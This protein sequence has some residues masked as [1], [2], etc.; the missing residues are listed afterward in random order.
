MVRGITHVI[1]NGLRWREAPAKYGPLH[2]RFVRWSG[3]DVFNRIL[4]GLARQ[5]G[6]PER[7]MIDTTHLE[8][9]RTT[10]SPL[11]T[12]VSPLQE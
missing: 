10:V 5:A 1:H 9:Q 4:A 11:H 2:N 7:L 6:E 8:A 3:L 12:T